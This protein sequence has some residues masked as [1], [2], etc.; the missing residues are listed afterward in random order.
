M[1]ISNTNPIV[2][3]PDITKQ[4]IKAAQ[5]M[6]SMSIGLI[7]TTVLIVHRAQLAAV[8]QKMEKQ[9]IQQ[10]PSIKWNAKQIAK[11]DQVRLFMARLV[12]AET[13]NHELNT[14]KDLNINEARE[15]ADSI[16]Q[17]LAATPPNPGIKILAPRAINANNLCSHRL[18]LIARQ[19]GTWQARPIYDPTSIVKNISITSLSGNDLG[20]LIVQMHQ[21]LELDI[22]DTFD[23]AFKN[24]SSQEPHADALRAVIDE[25][26][27]S[28]DDENKLVFNDAI[29][30]GSENNKVPIENLFPFLERTKPYENIEEVSLT[31]EQLTSPLFNHALNLNEK[32]VKEVRKTSPVINKKKEPSSSPKP[33]PKSRKKG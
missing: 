24:S 1:Q 5:E 17:E 22:D 29:N 21:N 7:I 16:A 9:E 19:V 23:E 8:L 11:A 3:V 32:L 12:V 14:F 15:K 30:L 2:I 26:L 18:A 13:L 27:Q 6:N 25:F 33:K 31:P 10:L 20:K 28:S 4:K